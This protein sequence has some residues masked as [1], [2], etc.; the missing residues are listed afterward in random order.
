VA[1][2]TQAGA[3]VLRGEVLLVMESMKMELQI[4]APRDGRVEALHVSAG[5]QV[6]L[7]AVLASLEPG[8]EERS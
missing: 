2:H 5:D 8:R 1:V 4:T 6:A 3:E 7:D